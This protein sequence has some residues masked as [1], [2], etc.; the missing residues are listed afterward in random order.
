MQKQH[1]RSRPCSPQRVLH[2]A[3]ALRAGLGCD[4]NRVAFNC[5]SAG[6]AEAGRTRGCAY[7]AHTATRVAWLI[8]ISEHFLSGIMMGPSIFE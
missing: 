4:G 1:S 8:M 3:L 5:K 2:H 6:A 7:T